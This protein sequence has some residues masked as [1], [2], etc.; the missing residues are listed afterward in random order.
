VSVR[1]PSHARALMIDDGDPGGAADPPRPEILASWHRSRRAGVDPAA[2]TYLLADPAGDTRLH[3][4]G[5]VALDAVAP[6][7]ATSAVVLVLADGAGRL[8]QRTATTESFA[9]AL[10]D[11]GVVVGRD[12][13]E[14]TVG[15]NA[16]GTALAIGERTTVIG[17]EHYHDTFQALAGVATPVHDPVAGHVLGAVGL[18]SPAGSTRP[19]HRAL[20]RQTALLVEQRMLGVDAEVHQRLLARY[21][22]A[23]R[24]PG[25]PVFAVSDQSLHA[26]PEAMRLL[27]GLSHED[28]WAPTYDALTLRPTPD[29]P[30][31]LPDG[32]RIVVRLEAIEVGGRLVGAVGEVLDDD[33]VPRPS[34]DRA[35]SVPEFRHWSPAARRTATALR[36]AAEDRRATCVVGEDGVGKATTVRIVAARAFPGRNLVQVAPEDATPGRIGAEL[37][38]GSPVLVADAHML[39][40]EQLLALADA[41]RDHRGGGWLALTYQGQPD[42]LDERLYESRLAILTASPLR[43]RPQ[44]IELA[45]PAM[46]RRY[47]GGRELALT[48]ALVDRLRREPWPTN[49]HGLEAVVAEIARRATKR[50]LDVGDLPEAFGAIL[51][52]RLTPMEWMTRSAIVAALQANG[53][54]KE[55]AAEALGMSRASIYRKIKAFD[56]DVDDLPAD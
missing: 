14:T 52:R 38:S 13:A 29:L 8:L 56:I 1:G 55:L 43:A 36:R 35:L 23:S 42:A 26:G 21:L 39:T 2:R 32:G 28:L 54:S 49:F 50:V 17:S 18:I 22:A 44:D 25:A 12:L 19:A 33:M 3:R 30:L 15:T 51:R 48:P 45:L 53:G 10:D 7:L 40:T 31:T 16:V 4:A 34:D 9:C 6:D 11:A 46:L 37:A 47:A 27:A 24:T 5:E 20:V 41:A